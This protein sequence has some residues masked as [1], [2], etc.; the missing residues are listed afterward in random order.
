[1]AIIIGLKNRIAA[2]RNENRKMRAYHSA[3]ASATGPNQRQE[4]ESLFSRG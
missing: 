4:I 1:M 2:R 3:I